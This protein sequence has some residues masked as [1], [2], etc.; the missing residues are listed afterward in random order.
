MT[1]PGRTR[2]VSGGANVDQDRRFGIGSAP[3]DRKACREEGIWVLREWPEEDAGEEDHFLA[4]HFDPVR[5]C[6][7]HVAKRPLY[8]L[9]EGWCAEQPARPSGKP[10][11]DRHASAV[12][13]QVLTFDTFRRCV[14]INVATLRSE[15][16]EAGKMKAEM[17]PQDHGT[18]DYGPTREGWSLNDE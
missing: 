16:R 7:W 2:C 12:Q 10:L 17:G 6:P 1:G 3:G 14:A 8:Q 11:V 4:A 15:S 9:R 13:V 5:F 18:T